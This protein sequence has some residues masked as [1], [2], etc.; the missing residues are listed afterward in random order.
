MAEKKESAEEKRRYVLPDGVTPG[1]YRTYSEALEHKFRWQDRPYIRVFRNE[2]EAQYYFEHKVEM[3]PPKRK[4]EP[5]G[6]ELFSEVENKIAIED[7]KRKDT[8]GEDPYSDL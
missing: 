5:K 8:T 4:Q 3:P 7:G 6:D 1:V 2:E